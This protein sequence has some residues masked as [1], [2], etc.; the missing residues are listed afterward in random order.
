MNKLDDDE[1]LRL[2]TR[3]NSPQHFILSQAGCTEEDAAEGSPRDSLASKRRSKSNI[4]P[5][6]DKAPSRSKKLEASASKSKQ[7]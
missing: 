2:R 3:Q 6:Q 5:F 4:I 1:A 7:R